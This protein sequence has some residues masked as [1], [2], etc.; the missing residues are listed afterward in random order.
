MAVT[1]TC[2]SCDQS[3]PVN[4]EV[5]GKKIRCKSCQEVFVATAAKVKVGGGSATASTNDKSPGRNGTTNGVHVKEPRPAIRSSDKG[6]SKKGL[7]IGGG[8]ALAATAG[9]M[10]WALFLR[11]NGSTQTNNN[12][13]P[14]NT[15]VVS[16]PS[17]TDTPTEK[18][19]ATE[20]ATKTESPPTTTPNVPAKPVSQS[21]KSTMAGFADSPKTIPPALAK[22]LLDKVKNSAVMIRI[23]I[24][25]GGAEGSGWFAEPGIIVTNAHVVNMVDPAAP[26]PHSIRVFLYQ[27]QPGKQREVTGKLLALD[28]ENDLAVISVQ[29]HKDLPDPLPICPSSE[30]VDGQQLHVMGFPLG[31]SFARMATGGAS[32]QDQAETTLKV[33]NTSVAGRVFYKN[34][35]VKYIQVEGGADHGNS[36]GAVFDNAGFVRSILVA[37]ISVTNMRFT[38]PSEY[39]VYLLQGRVLNVVPGQP[40]SA[41]SGVKMPITAQVAD[42]MHRIKKIHMEVWAGDPATQ[43]RTMSERR[44][45][46]LPGDS[47]RSE[48]ELAYDGDAVVKLGATRPATAEI[49]L[50]PIR[51]G[52]VYWIQPRYERIDG[53]TRW[54]EAIAT[55]WS[56]QP[57]DRR[58]AHL[59][60]KHQSGSQRF[61]RVRSSLGQ[62][63]VPEGMSVHIR[64]MEIRVAMTEKTREVESDGS[65]K[66]H[67]HYDDV[68]IGDRDMTDFYKEMNKELATA[69]KGMTTEFIMTNRGLIKSAKPNLQGVPQETRFILERFN[70]Q[71]IQ[72]LESLALALP[73]KDVGAGETWGFNIPYTFFLPQ[74]KKEDAV[75]RLR[76]KN[77]GVRT[78]NGREEAVVSFEG[79]VT[80]SDGTTT[81]A[82]EVNNTGEGIEKIDEAAERKKGIFGFIRGSALVDLQTG[83]TTLARSHADVVINFKIKVPVRVNNNVEEREINAT[84]GALSEAT[85]QRDFTPD[86]KDLTAEAYLPDLPLPLNPFVGAPD[87]SAVA[88]NPAAGNT[89]TNTQAPGVTGVSPLQMSAEVRERLKQQGCLIRQKGHDGGGDGS[90]WLAEPGI[91]VTNAHVIGM[92]DPASR[93]PISL[94]VYFNSGT[95]QEKKFPAK[96]LLVDHDNDLA[97]LEL[98]TKEGLPEPM[99]IVPSTYGPDP[100]YESQRLSVVGFP[101]GVSIGTDLGTTMDPIGAQIKMRES[102]VAGRVENKRTGLLKY[103]QVEGGLFPGNSGGAIVDMTGAVRCVAVA[104]IPDVDTGRIG[105]LGLAIPSEYAARLLAGFPL[106]TEPKL[107]YKDG[108]VAKMP[109][110]IKFGDPLRRVKSVHLD[111]WMGKPGLPRRNTK[112]APK[113]RS[114]DTTRQSVQ[115]NYDP[116]EMKA[117]G[118]F[119]LPEV[120]PGMCYWVQARYVDGTGKE[121]WGDAISFGGET[122]TERRPV[123]LEARFPKGG[124]QMLDI[125]TEAD[126]RYVYLGSNYAEENNL[127]VSMRETYL[128]PS[129]L[130]K[131]EVVTYQYENLSFGAPRTQGQYLR[132]LLSL[133]QGGGPQLLILIRNVVSTT[134]YSKDGVMQPNAQVT[135]Q[136]FAANLAPHVK[137]LNDQVLQSIQVM[138]LR[139]PNKVVE[140]G[141]TWEQPTNLLIAARNRYEGALFKLQMKYMGVRDRG[142]RS[143]AVIE[144]KGSVANDP[145]AKTETSELKTESEDENGG[146]PKAPPKGKGP[147]PK[148]KGSKPKPPGNVSADLDIQLAQAS[149]PPSTAKSK[150]PLYG[151]IK[152]V[153]YIDV[154]SGHVSYCK[155]FVDID[156]EVMHVDQQTKAQIPV[157]AGG[158]MELE[159]KRRSSA[160]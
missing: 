143:E 67:L 71:I 87:A 136:G 91:V 106:K 159:L 2:P 155:L 125:H 44:P 58:S 53:S 46:P 22:D 127:V 15:P 160:R 61:V 123:R 112:T 3:L 19:T 29:G 135:F 17:L 119:V 96:I 1:V 23:L 82:G 8:V 70:H 26:P 75:Y 36:G 95:P 147:A 72:S 56:G 77:L 38:I 59:S 12:P 133:I 142:G 45:A 68:N 39:A 64:P 108:A 99:P 100:L 62:G 98:P 60:L 92:L 104:V 13:Q 122:P 16:K 110:E 9:V 14:V 52:Q 66:I 86:A 151:D 20:V 114:D 149:L 48:A 140:Y 111:Y 65:A 105:Q 103:I 76:F 50:P 144:I 145:N 153:A 55:Q 94:D 24:D 63:A 157:R 47:A 115:C 139:F 129:K 88:S 137:Q 156:V 69:A 57:V 116:K 121:V 130:A 124:G 107:A 132:A 84:F 79:F 83:F 126:Y 49:D 42:P 41:G 5:L 102:S 33:R 10:V 93:P 25:Q 27:G 120:E 109:V 32:P 131:G 118:E 81:T 141:E 35:G 128:G 4:D 18:N 80:K 158:T 89:N 6:G 21:K 90:G 113:P 97:V 40:Y 146:T 43:T 28:R 78:R 148:D 138:S 150:K 152:G 101:K 134:A 85:L 34:G 30:L 154:E 54:G 11:D 73:D 37:G 74:N 31:S 51:P 117:L 7:M